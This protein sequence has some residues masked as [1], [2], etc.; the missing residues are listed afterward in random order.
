[1]TEDLEMAKDIL[2]MLEEGVVLSDGGM[3]I[4]ARRRGYS[5]PEIVA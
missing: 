2:Q 3:I 1:M 4:E 5:T